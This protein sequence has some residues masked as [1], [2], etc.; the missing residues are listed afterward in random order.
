MLQLIILNSF[1]FITAHWPIGLCFLT[2]RASCKSCSLQ[3]PKTSASRTTTYL[4]G[5]QQGAK[6]EKMGG[7]VEDVVMSCNCDVQISSHIW[8]YSGLLVVGA[9]SRGALRC[10]YPN[11]FSRGNLWCFFLFDCFFPPGV[12]KVSNCFTSQGNV[13]CRNC[14]VTQKW[15]QHIRGASGVL[16]K[17]CSWN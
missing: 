7:L 14:M 15:Y 4:A 8:I 6:R 13:N 11:I 1:N 3:G 9:R 17:N 10:L 5:G 12:R 16:E 2:T